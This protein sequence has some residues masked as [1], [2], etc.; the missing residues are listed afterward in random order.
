M[1]HIG[2]SRVCLV[3]FFL[4]EEILLRNFKP[5]EVQA[6]II[7]GNP[8]AAAS[9]MSVKNHLSRLG[10]FLKNPAIQCYRFLSRVDALFIQG[11]VPL[12]DMSLVNAFENTPDR[13]QVEKLIS[14][15]E[16]MVNGEV[17]AQ[18]GL[19]SRFSET[20]EKHSWLTSSISSLLLSWLTQLPH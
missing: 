19:L 6:G 7:G 20:M 11:F 2:L 10:I 5:G 17:P 14:L 18:K 13:E 1:K 9:N 4:Q 16:M 3:A 12:L 15:V 8:T